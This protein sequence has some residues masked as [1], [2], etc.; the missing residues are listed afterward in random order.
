MRALL[1]DDSAAVSADEAM[2]IAAIRA[3][4]DTGRARANRNRFPL[5]K[6]NPADSRR[7]ALAWFAVIAVLAVVLVLGFG[8]LPSS[9]PG[10]IPISKPSHPASGTTMP[11]P[12]TTLP[13][14]VT[15]NI[16]PTRTITS[17]GVA[18]DIA[19]TADGVYWLTYNG[20]QVARAPVTPFRYSPASG[21][22]IKGPSITGS[23]GS[24]AIT[25][26]GGWVWVVV[27]VGRNVVVE[28][29]DI[30]T[31]VLHS[32]ESLPV[33]DNM[34]ATGVNPLL[35]ATV[36]G[37]LWVAG[38]DDL[39]ELNPSTGAIEREFD[40]GNSIASMSTDPT[41]TLLY[42]GGWTTTRGNMTVTQYDALTGRELRR[43]DQLAVSPGT[44]AATD[45][46]VW[47][48]LRTGN[49]GRAFE[50]SVTRLSE[51]APP[52]NVATSLGIYD[53]IGG[54]ESSISEGTLWL[55]S[56]DEGDVGSLTCA[57]PATG[58]VRASESVQVG[59]PIASG[60][61]LYAFENKDLVV[62]TPP[63]KCFG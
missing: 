32:S 55:T 40:S 18:Q 31:L 29:L 23:V 44:V 27:G 47:V 49:Y 16:W 12:T 26:T 9:K 17:T 53:Q 5:W 28:Q 15:R 45:G 13:P 38:G 7:P 50:L 54:V 46:G 62:I 20:N 22:V 1:P 60:P 19:P 39:W 6:L 2:A 14:R 10:G 48:T 34:F 33:K 61:L 25:V 63:A 37:P 51:I 35:T 30:S 41:G 57:D 3:R 36:N 58:A 42:T 8:A 59:D 21:R 56:S 43:S 4:A 52:S 11:G 24:P